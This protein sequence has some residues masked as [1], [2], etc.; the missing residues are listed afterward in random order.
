ME[1]IPARFFEDV[2]GQLTIFWMLPTNTEFFGS[3]GSCARKLIKNGHR[4]TV[5]IENG[6]FTDFFFNDYGGT[7]VQSD[8]SN[9]PTKFKIRNDIEYVVSSTEV[10]VITV[11]L[12]KQ[13]ER[14]SME[15]ALLRLDLY[16]LIDKKWVELFSSL[17][18]LNAIS[19]DYFDPNVICLLER[20]LSQKQILQLV[21]YS[22]Y[23]EKEINLFRAFFQQEQF[24]CLD[25]KFWNN[26]M[27]DWI[28][29][30]KGNNDLR[31][32]SVV[33]RC[34]EVLHDASFEDCGFTD[35]GVYQFINAD[36]KVCYCVYEDTNHNDFAK[37]MEKVDC[38]FVEFTR[39]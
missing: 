30:C 21:V 24:Q 5:V 34:R 1:K 36:V 15:P 37:F 28:M 3:F 26:D 16:G 9:F 35:R 23:G 6:E 7:L 13:L 38:S 12:R 17:Q 14:L 22:N 8:D 2:L 29:A 4:K 33:W 11:K 27:H 19:V 39:G 20:L 32:K 25:F 31:G 10:P 18:K